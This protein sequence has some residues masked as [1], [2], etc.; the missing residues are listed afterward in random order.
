MEPT[1]K[2]RFRQLSDYPIDAEAFKHHFLVFIAREFD[3]DSTMRVF[4]C[5]N[6]TGVRERLYALRAFAEER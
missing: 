4:F 1:C 2:P 6:P 3:V 5:Q